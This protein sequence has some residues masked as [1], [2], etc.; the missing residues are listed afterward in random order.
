VQEANA[1]SARSGE[2]LISTS[3]FLCQPCAGTEVAPCGPHRGG[4]HPGG[5]ASAAGCTE[6]LSGV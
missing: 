3:A 6:P 4:T 5:P 2:F 1:L